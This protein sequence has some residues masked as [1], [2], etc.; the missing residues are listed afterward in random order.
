MALIGTFELINFE[1]DISIDTP[2]GGA[3]SAFDPTDILDICCEMFSEG[4]TEVCPVDTG[5]L[6]SSISAITDGNGF[7]AIADTD[8]A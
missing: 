7:I 3:D 1:N 6:V 8:Y 2:W 4:S 5:L